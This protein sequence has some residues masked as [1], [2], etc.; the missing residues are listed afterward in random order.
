[1]CLHRKNLRLF[2]LGLG[3]GL[4]LSFLIEP[5]FWRLLLAAAA[6][7]AAILMDNC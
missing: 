2:L 3:I 6:I 1:M 4:L 7:A 5:W